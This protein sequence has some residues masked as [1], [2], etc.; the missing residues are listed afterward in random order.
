M[1][2]KIPNLTISNFKPLT[3]DHSFS[4]HQLSKWNQ[5]LDHER[6]KTLYEQ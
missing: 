2:F 3:K 4:L 6:L 5:H 1:D